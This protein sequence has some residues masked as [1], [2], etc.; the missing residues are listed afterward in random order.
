MKYGSTVY[1]DNALA[2]DN[3]L[4]CRFIHRWLGVAN[5][6]K[7]GCRHAGYLGLAAGDAGRGRLAASALKSGL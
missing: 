4:Q 3:A 7:L 6:R 5:T 1:T 2:Y